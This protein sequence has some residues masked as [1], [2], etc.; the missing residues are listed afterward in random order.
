VFDQLLVQLKGIGVTI[1]LASVATYIICIVV[2]KTIGFRVDK[3]EEQFG[4]DKSLHG[5]RGYDFS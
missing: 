2:E 4:L 3:E 5:E 1:A